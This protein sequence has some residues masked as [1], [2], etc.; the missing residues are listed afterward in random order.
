MLDRAIIQ[1]VKDAVDLVALVGQAVKLRKQGGAWTGLCPFHSEKT[2]SFQ[3]VGD[4]GFYHCFGCGKHGDALTWL[5]ERDG[6]TFGEALEH[7]ANQAGISLPQNR[8]R[9]PA[10]VGLETRLRAAMEAAQA[11]FEA[12]LVESASAMDYLQNA[13]GIQPDF[14]ASAGFGYA[15][16]QWEALV[17]HLARNGYSNDLIEQTGLAARSERGNLVDFLRHRITIPIRDHRGRIIAFG[18]RALGDAKPKYLNTRETSLFQKGSTLYGLH[19]AKGHM[20]DGAL[21]VEG[22]FDVLQLHQ[23]RVNCAVATLGTALTEHHIALLKRFTRKLVLCFDGDNAGIKAMDKALRLA[24]PAG[25][26]IRLLCLPKEEDPDTFCMKIGSEAFL[27][28]LQ[29]APD[30]TSF[31]I[32]RAFEGKNTRRIQDRMEAL[33][34]LVEFLRYLPRAEETTSLLASLAHQLQLPLHELERAIYAKKPP[35]AT[36][37]AGAPQP[38][39]TALL[40][41]EREVDDLIRPLLILCQG[42][43]DRDLIRE[44]PSSWWD[45]LQGAAILQAVLDADGD[46]ETLPPELLAALRALRAAWAPK[47][48]ATLDAARVLAKIEAAYVQHE[49]QAINRQL[50]EPAIVSDATMTSKL[51]D[52]LGELLVRKSALQK[53]QRTARAQ[54]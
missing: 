2:P 17:G 13:R 20:Q 47:D 41:L 3:V 10:E 11:F 25:F 30:W 52:R 14:M 1:Q 23:Q 19:H 38:S 34:E 5:Q 18:G 40:N 43:E 35:A 36:P 12:R 22:Y 42:Q 15:P 7:L 39:T 45:G 37:L 33:Q 4:K 53:Q 31:V 8:E 44:K 32:D 50:Q 28:L 29:K 9:N 21:L 6:Y 49:I 51:E 27:D 48:D 24:L 46:D 26:D 54:A 16:D